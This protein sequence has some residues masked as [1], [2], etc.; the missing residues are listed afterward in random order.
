[1]TDL[2]PHTD[3]WAVIVRNSSAEFNAP[4]P[5]VAAFPDEN[6]AIGWKKEREE[7]QK[8]LHKELHKPPYPLGETDASV[9][10]RY[11]AGW[12]LGKFGQDLGEEYFGMKLKPFNLSLM[13]WQVL[14]SK[15]YW[16]DGS[17]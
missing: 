7:R 12:L 11:E 3:I 8:T 6:F 15:L 13:Y 4:D 17:F 1:M 16:P 14:P 2:K 10:H 9:Y 5:V